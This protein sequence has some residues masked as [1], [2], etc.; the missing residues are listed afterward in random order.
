MIDMKALDAVPGEEV[1]EIAAAARHRDRMA[2]LSLRTG[3]IDRG[4][5]MPVE[6][7]GMVQQMEDAHDPFPV[8]A[9][10]ANLRLLSRPDRAAA[11]RKRQPARGGSLVWLRLRLTA[12]TDS[13]RAPPRLRASRPGRSADS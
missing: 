3:Q 9:G 12:R 13:R 5:N 11:A 10:V 2:E 4:M 8:E 6:A 1:V 7:P